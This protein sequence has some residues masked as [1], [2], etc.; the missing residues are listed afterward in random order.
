MSMKGPARPSSSPPHQKLPRS[1]RTTRR[2]AGCRGAV[3]AQRECEPQGNRLA[4]ISCSMPAT[5]AD[6]KAMGT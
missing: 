5:E 3:R 4:N 6:N 1:S 2:T